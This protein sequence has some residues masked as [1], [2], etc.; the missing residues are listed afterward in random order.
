MP[1]IGYNPSMKSKFYSTKEAAQALGL[2]PDHVK[3]LARDGNI[4]AK[5]VGRD[6]VVLSLDYK[7]KRKL[8]AKK[9]KW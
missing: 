8:K 3:R 9:G 1:V 4:K 7:R 6:W 2:S 5:K